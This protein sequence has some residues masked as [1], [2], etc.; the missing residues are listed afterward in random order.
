MSLIG[1]IFLTTESFEPDL[2]ILSA[3]GAETVHG[4]DSYWKTPNWI[5]VIRGQRP[6]KG[7]KVTRSYFLISDQKPCYLGSAGISNCSVIST[8]NT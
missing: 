6:V 2:D 7:E 8:F 5:A 1:R 3:I 4:L